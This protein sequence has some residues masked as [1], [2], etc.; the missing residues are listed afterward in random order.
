M[1]TPTVRKRYNNACLRFFLFADEK[2]LDWD[3]DP[4]EVDES[5]AQYIDKLWEE[6]DPRYWGEDV[7]SGLAHAAKG[8]KGKLTLSWQLITAWQKH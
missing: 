6:G 5:I 1:F 2:D 7:L 8:L 4:G 3:K